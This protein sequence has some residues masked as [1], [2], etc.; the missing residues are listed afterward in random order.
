MV[1]YLVSYKTKDDD[2]GKVKKTLNKYRRY[3]EF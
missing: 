2:V 1:V 3:G